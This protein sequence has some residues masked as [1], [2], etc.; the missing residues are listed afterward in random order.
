M[1]A[2]IYSKKNL[3]SVLGDDDF[4]EWIKE[5]FQDFR[6]HLEIPEYHILAPDSEKIM[7]LVSRRFKIKRES[8]KKSKRGKENVARD[9]AVYLLRIYSN[10]TLTG[11]FNITNYSTVNSIIERVK[12]R[13]ATDIVF[14]NQLKNL[15]KKLVKGQRKA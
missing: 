9:L 11:V 2:Y 3:A 1:A 5:K 10:K 15:E 6:F 4:K 7:D 8:F 14:S 12:A 13:K